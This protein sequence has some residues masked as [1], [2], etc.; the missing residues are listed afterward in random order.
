MFIIAHHVSYVHSSCLSVL[1]SSRNIPSLSDV[2]KIENQS[3]PT[4]EFFFFFKATLLLN[5]VGKTPSF[6]E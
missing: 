2:F 4:A 1:S 6:R 5:A 3:V